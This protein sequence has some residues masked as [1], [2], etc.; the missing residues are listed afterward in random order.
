MGS[1]THSA[2]GPLPMA[3]S[4]AAPIANPTAV[5]ASARNAVDPVDAALVRN[6]DRVPSTTQ[7]ACCTPLRSA[8]ATAAA[9]PTAPRVAFRN[10]TERKLACLATIPITPEAA[11]SRRSDGGPASWPPYQLRRWTAIVSGSARRV[12]MSASEAAVRTATAMACAWNAF[13]ASARTC[14]ALPARSRSRARSR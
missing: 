3:S 13:A 7:N 1:A 9:R 2:T 12:A 14:S 4:S 10:H 11:A 6:T 5:P 8:M